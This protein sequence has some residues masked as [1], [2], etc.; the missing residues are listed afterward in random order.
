MQDESACSILLFGKASGTHTKNIWNMSR[1]GEVVMSTS[2][3]WCSHHSMTDINSD[4]VEWQT[5]PRNIWLIVTECHL[6]IKITHIANKAN[7]LQQ[8]ILSRASA[9]WWRK[10]HGALRKMPM[11]SLWICGRI[12]IYMRAS[13]NHWVPTQF[14]DYY[15]CV[16]PNKFGQVSVSS[17]KMI[18]WKYFSFQQITYFFSTGR[19]FDVCDVPDVWC[20][21]CLEA[22]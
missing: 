17:W 19:E 2:I 8:T 5:H 3:C 1:G 4:V 12:W 16:T 20:E 10:G 22:L 6:Q 11:T 14:Q 13:W 7:M 15:R 18:T 21:R 9:E